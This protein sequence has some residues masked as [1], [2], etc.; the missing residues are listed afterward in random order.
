MSEKEKDQEWQQELITRLASSALTEQRRSRRWGIFFKLLMFSYLITVLLMI[1]EPEWLAEPIESG[2]HTAVVD[3]EGVI[4]RGQKA[5]ADRVIKGLTAAFEDENSA[6]VILRINSPG[7][8]PVQ[9]GI[10]YDEMRR[11][12]KQY[13][14]TP[15]YAVVDDVCASGGYYIAAAADKIYADQASIVGSIGV[16]MDGFG[17]VEAMKSLGVERRL[18]TAGSNKALLDPF[19]PQKA[20]QSAH[21]ET[22]LNEIHQQFIDKVKEGRGDRLQLDDPLLFSGLIWSGAEGVKKGLVDALANVNEV[23]RDVV[24]EEKIVNFT[25]SDDLLTRF[26]DRIGATMLNLFSTSNRTAPQLLP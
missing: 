22:L 19:L 26:S 20:E 25:E 17:F 18:L 5:D 24:G 6:A 9:S 16:R 3:L 4:A 11:L 13:P 1:A 2:K 10:I 8:S 12:R 14:E 15:L 21:I 23:A 7:G